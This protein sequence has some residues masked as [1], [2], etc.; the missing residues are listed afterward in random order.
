MSLSRGRWSRRVVPVVVAGPVAL[1]ASLVLGVAP[2][3]A[4]TATASGAA[5]T[6]AEAHPPSAS[7]AL[8][9]VSQSNWVE[10]AQAGAPANFT[11][12]LS[13]PGAPRGAQV[14]VNLFNRLHTRTGFEATLRKPPGQSDTRQID[15]TAPVALSSLGTSTGGGLDL[16]IDVVPSP[17]ASSAAGGGSPTLALSCS[18]GAT[19]TGVYPAVV[20]L[21][22]ASGAELG[23]FTTYLTYVQAT[24]ADRL[25][26]AWVV[27]ISATTSLRP[28][29]DPGSAL[30]PLAHHTAT[31]LERLVGDL[32]AS[33]VPVTLE[34]VPQTLQ[35][36]AAAGQP[37]EGAVKTLA[38]MAS[39]PSVDDTVAETYVPVD[40]GALAGAGEP[41][42]ITAQT[43]RATAVLEK[44]GVDVA[45]ATS[46]VTT[47]QVGASTGTG[48]AQ[49]GAERVVVPDTQLAP[50]TGKLTSRRSTDTWSWPFPLSFGVK[51]PTVTAAA[52]DSV[53]ASHFTTDR[54]DPALAAATLLADLAMVHFEA[55]NT[56]VARGMVAVAPSGWAPTV[57]F[58]HQLLSGLVDNPVVQPVTL[59]G[60]FATVPAPPGV[61]RHLQSHRA[62]RALPASLARKLSA[63][64]LR[65]TAFDGAVPSSPPVLGQL[66]D[67]LLA[68]EA[69]YRSTRG[70]RTAVAKYDRIFGH[71]LSLVKL[72]TDQSII[73]LTAQTGWIPV[74]VQSSAPYTIVG[75][76]TLSSAKFKFPPS[77][78]GCTTKSSAA[79]AASIVARSTSC[80]LEL[81]HATNPVRI[82]V[83]A[84]TLGDSP[85]KVA[86]GVPGLVFARGQMTV[87]STA[88]SVVGV[89]LTAVALA[90]LLAWWART[91]RRGRRRRRGARE[92][93]ARGS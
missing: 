3:L 17:S 9:L 77:G 64:R 67:A 80:S 53:L 45:T 78:S 48:L 92:A 24:S 47:G 20:A 31:R 4:G 93:L 21:T 26:F 38:N 41:T 60:Y 58:D 82:D 27:P 73:T 49:L 85:V 83:H 8:S 75:R 68:S 76:L 25:R 34:P 89:V 69:R 61:T 74:S 54:H 35:A 65:L 32:H 59:S 86:F 33:H 87:R 18:T 70:M 55:P 42:E 40:L 6:A 37:G 39:H 16:R 10:P 44:Y 7:P 15:H 56:Q 90:V 57:A 51:G 46:W 36:L 91:W 81:D 30:S 22:S 14:S 63:A 71:Q 2:A 23:R 19:C 43:K 62:D 79:P 1:L 66:D 5:G 88:T 52:A 84:R 11:L 28:G 13:A 12:V 50:S 72:S 29:A